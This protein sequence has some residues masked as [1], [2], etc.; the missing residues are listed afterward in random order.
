MPGDQLLERL[1]EDELVRILTSWT[2]RRRPPG[3]STL[4]W[5]CQTYAPKIW[6]SNQ[7]YSSSR[8]NLHQA[9]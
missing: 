6:T 8:K 4:M 9:V 7:E 5:G 1:S 2:W 3:S